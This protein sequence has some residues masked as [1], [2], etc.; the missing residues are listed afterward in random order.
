MGL[1]HHSENALLGL[2]QEQF[3]LPRSKV[4]R[5]CLSRSGI[6]NKRSRRYVFFVYTPVWFITPDQSIEFLGPFQFDRLP[7]C[8]P[9]FQLMKR[10]GVIGV[11][12]D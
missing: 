11:R 12:K 10:M 4:S 6:L 3:H 8:G 9:T 1:L 7:H 5:N 2:I